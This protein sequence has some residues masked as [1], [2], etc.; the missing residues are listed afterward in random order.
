LFD[1]RT[2]HQ[3]QV[4][5]QPGGSDDRTVTSTAFSSSDG[6]LFADIPMGIASY[7]ILYSEGMKLVNDEGQ[8]YVLRPILKYNMLG[9]SG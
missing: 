2:V 8:L 7:G 6:L 3:L 9:G 1:M 4:C 5:Q